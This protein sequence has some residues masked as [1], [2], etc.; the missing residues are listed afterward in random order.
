MQDVLKAVKNKTFEMLAKA[1][2]NLTVPLPGLGVLFAAKLKDISPSVAVGAFEIT[3]Q[4]SFRSKFS[5]TAGDEDIVFSAIAVDN[6]NAEQLGGMAAVALDL[7]SLSTGKEVSVMGLEEP[8]QIKLP[9]ILN[10]SS[11]SCVYWD[12]GTTQWSTQGVRVGSKSVLGGHLYC[13]TTHFSFFGAI[14]SGIV[15]TILCANFDMFTGENIKEVFEGDWPQSIG[16]SIFFTLMGGVLLLFGIAAMLDH[17]RWKQYHWNDEYFLVPS[18]ADV[19]HDHDPKDDAP[20]EEKS[21]CTPKTMVLGCLAAT[22]ICPSDSLK[23]AIDEICSTWF[24]YFGELRELVESICSG[25]NGLWGGPVSMMGLALV[26]SDKM[27]KKMLLAN[28][29]RSTAASLGMSTDLVTFVLESKELGSFIVEGEA[30]KRSASPSKLPPQEFL[31]LRR[32]RSLSFASEELKRSKSAR[33]PRSR[34]KQMVNEEACSHVALEEEGTGVHVEPEAVS[35]MLLPMPSAGTSFPLAKDSAEEGAA[36]REVSAWRQNVGQN[37]EVPSGISPTPLPP[38]DVSVHW[39]LNVDQ[40][41]AWSLLT[42]E[43]C[44][45]LRHQTGRKL[46][47]RQHAWGV[48]HTLI[49]LNPIGELFCIDIFRTAK[50]KAALFSADLLGQFVMVAVFFQ[51]AGMVVRKSR[52]GDD[53]C[54]GGSDESVGMR[55]GRFLV[56]ATASFLLAGCPVTILESLTNKGLKKIEG[57]R[58]S[59]AWQKQLRSWQIQERL[60]WIT[61][62]TFNGFCAFYLL[63]FVANIAPDSYGDFTLAASIGVI[64]DVMAFPLVMALFIPV[65]ARFFLFV[66]SRATKVPEEEVVRKTREHLHDETNMMLPIHEV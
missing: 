37:A 58:G 36:S 33:R 64:E 59:R 7:H 17:H 25:C 6:D 65:L 9:I 55:I 39:R 52:G 29:R 43:V 19:K 8:V 18:V 30:A 34:V 11:I 21:P 10:G 60:F 56:I 50:Q 42:E 2:G 48:C 54:G 61:S 22:C 49:Y 12:E 63:V 13:E 23:D 4:E 14:A 57:A 51:G 3:L 66:H 27:V 1:G 46:T 31:G 32:I 35:S 5:G 20:A 45:A 40:L 62:I 38:S 16:A 41:R 15:T 26:L 28:S 53:A 24:E 47:K 44:E